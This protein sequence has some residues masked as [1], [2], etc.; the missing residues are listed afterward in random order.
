MPTKALTLCRYPGC[1]NLVQ[2]GYCDDHKGE[3]A[4]GWVRDEVVQRLY[5]SVKWKRIRRLQLS[6]EPWCAACLAQGNYTEATDVDHIEPHGGDLDKFFTG[7]LQSLCHSCH[8]T[9]TASEVNG[10]RGGAS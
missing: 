10:R 4:S 6:R 7:K 9:K 3:T 5:N 1:A 8:S 2:S